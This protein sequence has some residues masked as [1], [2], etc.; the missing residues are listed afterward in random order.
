MRQAC[1]GSA[2]RGSCGSQPGTSLLFHHP[3]PYRSAPRRDKQCLRAVTRQ[4]RL[5]A[6]IPGR[7]TAAGG[8][9][10]SSSRVPDI[11]DPDLARFPR[12]ARTQRSRIE[13]LLT[14][15]D[16][17]F[18]PPLWFHHVGAPAALLLLPSLTRR[19]ALPPLLYREP[20]TRCVPCPPS[21]LV[22]VP[23]MPD[24]SVAINVFWREHPA[25][26]Y[27]PKDIYGNKDLPAFDA[28]HASASK[29]GQ[30]MHLLGA[31]DGVALCVRRPGQTGRAGCTIASPEPH[32]QKRRAP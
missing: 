30:V 16:A 27:N 28:A 4:K 23:A 26:I 25:E 21:Y 3:P 9:T 22:R 7:L 17:V 10:G 6:C 8:A 20:L 13:G 14:P 12:F 2:A 32:W 5:H 24:F 1:K 11:H 19:P 15:G 31:G 29:A 18:I